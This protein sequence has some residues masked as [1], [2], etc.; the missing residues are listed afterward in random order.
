MA[1]AAMARVHTVRDRD[2]V[3]ARGHLQRCRDADDAA[4]G[5]RELPGAW[6]L[7]PIPVRWPVEISALAPVAWTSP[8]S[9]FGVAMLVPLA[10]ILTTRSWG[11]PSPV[12]HRR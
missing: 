4:A 2:E 10:L 11:S 9:A 1:M 5:Y 8:F 3:L 12:Q 6:A 7:G